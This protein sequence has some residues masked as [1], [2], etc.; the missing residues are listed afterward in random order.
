MT[1]IG[2]MHNAI[3][4]GRVALLSDVNVVLFTQN[5]AHAR[6]AALGASQKVFYDSNLCRD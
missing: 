6:R 4:T 5:L 1:V 2:L 3:Y